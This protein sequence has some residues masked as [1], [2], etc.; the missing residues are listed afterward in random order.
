[1][2]RHWLLC[3]AAIVA[4]TVSC[5]GCGSTEKDG[6]ARPASN[7]SPNATEQGATQEENGDEETS[8]ADLDVDN[9]ESP[10]GVVNRFIQSFFNGDGDAA[11]AMLTEKARDAQR[12]QFAAQASDSIRWSIVRKTKRDQNRARVVVDVE[13]YADS[14]DLQT[15]EL[16]FLTTNDAG[17]WRVAGFHVGELVVDFENSVIASVDELDSDSPRAALRDDATRR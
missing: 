14:G 16:T 5:V 9:P 2:K 12:D 17:K 15:D 13:D 8:G 6:A 4:A 11:F 7:A 3:V 1:M 10:E